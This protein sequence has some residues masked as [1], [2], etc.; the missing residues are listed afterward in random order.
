LGDERLGK[1]VLFL[2]S[3]E[4]IGQAMQIQQ[5][6][7]YFIDEMK[8]V[9]TEHVVEEAQDAVSRGAEV[10]IARGNQAMKIKQNLTVPVVDIRATAQEVGLLLAEAKKVADIPHPR[11][12][13]IAS[14]NMLP[15]IS[16]LSEIYDVEL[17]V[18]TFYSNMDVYLLIKKIAENPPDVIISGSKEI[19][20][21]EEF[22]IKGVYFSQTQD[23]LREAFRVAKM[24]KY[25]MDI[26][27]KSNA[28]IKALVDN[29]FTGIMRTDQS[30]TIILVN[31][32]MRGILHKKEREIIG[33]QITRIFPG[34][35]TDGVRRVLKDGG[36]VF[37]TYLVIKDSAVNLIMTPIVVD[38]DIEGLILF[39]YTVKKLQSPAAGTEKDIRHSCIS[40]EDICHESKSMQ[41]CMHL[42]R[43][44]VQSVNP[45]LIT[46][47]AGTEK[48]ELAE[49]M[50]H[51][52]Q[53]KYGPFVSVDCASVRDDRQTAVIFG[54]PYEDTITG[55]ACRAEN[56]VLLLQN[57]EYLSL[58][59]QARLLEYLQGSSNNPALRL[60]ATGTDVA[61]L[62][63]P[64]QFS[65]ELYCFISGLSLKIPPL[66][67]RRED[68]ERSLDIYF[69]HYKKRYER[70]FTLTKSA[71]RHI[72]DQ[73]WYGN[74]LQLERF[75]ERV[76]LTSDERVIN[77]AFV[78]SVMIE[79]NGVY[80]PKTNDAFTGEMTEQERILSLLEKFH[81]NRQKIA[82]E[83]GISKVTLW[84]RMKDYGME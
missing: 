83:M 64:E 2:P 67:K 19:K 32:K 77:E 6:Q 37:S 12:A 74:L 17:K 72:L 27:K 71:R 5:N 46:G 54:D 18:H 42:A 24:M 25:A 26:E 40:F 43:A 34:L 80:R 11:I 3:D 49:V 47:E 66:R 51:C 73:P 68:L 44:Y 70:Y 4:L 9:V 10:I 57:I 56:G 76:I 39:C 60:I 1:I 29:S 58:Q 35:E 69:E 55:A 48:R 31:E 61:R 52:S 63:D 84:R 36:A 16:H 50:Y 53:F 38:G 14:K 81:G 30:G 21:A 78:R 79:F 23:G 62:S 7:E 65:Y 8:R 28:Q 20:I 22:G 13:I 41:K 45:V 82:D 75:C 15:D 59:N 33:K